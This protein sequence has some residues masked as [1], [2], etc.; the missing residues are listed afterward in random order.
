MAHIL[1]LHHDPMQRHLLS[2]LLQQDSHH[3]MSCSSHEDIMR[4]ID[5]CDHFDGIVFDLEMIYFGWGPYRQA[6]EMELLSCE[7]HTPILGLSSHYADSES[8]Q[9]CEKFQLNA[10]LALP[11]N[12]HHFRQCVQN[13]VRPSG[14]MPSSPRHS[15]D[16]M[17]SPDV[18]A[19]YEET[20]SMVSLTF[21]DE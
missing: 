11:V 20:C 17:R 19:L 6:G 18:E 7:H 4:C 12:P 1:L 10:F 2:S 16:D 21:G 15:N 5:A 9:I 14:K 3:L 8:Q 13:L